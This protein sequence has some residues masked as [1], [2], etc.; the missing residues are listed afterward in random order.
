MAN[1]PSG[2]VFHATVA[3]LGGEDRPL[4]SSEYGHLHLQLKEGQYTVTVSVPA[5]SSSSAAALLAPRTKVVEVVRGEFTDVVYA[6]P[7]QQPAVPR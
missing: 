2:T 5:Q 3:E 4:T 1:L 6:L 7:P